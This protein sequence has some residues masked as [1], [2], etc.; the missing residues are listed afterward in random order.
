MTSTGSTYILDNTQEFDNLFTCLSK[1]YAK[2]ISSGSNPEKIQIRHFYYGVLHQT[3]DFKFARK[4]IMFSSST[5]IT[6]SDLYPEFSALDKVLGERIKLRERS[7]NTKSIAKDNSASIKQ[8]DDTLDSLRKYIGLDADDDMFNGLPKNMTSVS[9][10]FQSLRAVASTE[11]KP[12]K[13]IFKIENL[14][15]GEKTLKCD[16]SQDSIKSKVSSETEPQTGLPRNLRSFL[17]DKMTFQQVYEK[18]KT[19]ENYEE[20]LPDFFAGKYEVMLLLNEDKHLSFNNLAEID[21]NNVTQE[22]F[23]TLAT[24]FDLFT[25]G[26]ESYKE[27]TEETPDDLGENINNITEMFVSDEIARAKE[28]TCHN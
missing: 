18:L 7:T 16:I 21:P 10:D 27:A 17:G 1:T 25:L 24:E 22:Q 14:N 28:P 4:L 9:T 20:F 3:Y 8:L 23:D 19:E 15:C 11:R 26:M 5:T 2:I 12:V 13:R 6:V